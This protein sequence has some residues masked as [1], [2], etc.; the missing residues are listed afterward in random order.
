MLVIDKY[1]SQTQLIFQL[2]TNQSDKDNF[3]I[4]LLL[5]RLYSLYF[6]DFFQYKC[7]IIE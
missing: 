6:R 4:K 3:G 2:I 7:R 5:F 1:F